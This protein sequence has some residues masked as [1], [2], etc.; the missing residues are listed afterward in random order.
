[1]RYVPD[2]AFVYVVATMVLLIS[3]NI[4]H[5][6]VISL[7]SILDCKTVCR[8]YGS[9]SRAHTHTQAVAINL[10]CRFFVIGN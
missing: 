10:T 7:Y 6:N 9:V 4:L 1:M 5:V 2:V 3:S 8:L